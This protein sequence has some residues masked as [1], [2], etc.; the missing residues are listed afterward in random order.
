MTIRD[1]ST[2][3]RPHLRHEVPI[4]MWTTL[5][6]R[7]VAASLDVMLCPRILRSSRN[8]WKSPVFLSASLSFG[9]ISCICWCPSHLESIQ[10]KLA[11]E[12]GLF[13]LSA[14]CRIWKFEGIPSRHWSSPEISS[15][16]PWSTWFGGTPVMDGS[17]FPILMVPPLAG[18]DYHR[19]NRLKL[20]DSQQKKNCLKYQC[21]L[22][23]RAMRA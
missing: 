19:I 6:Q 2:G 7:A 4:S 20:Q 21:A 5:V 9:H 1:V 14:G 22:Q 16:K 18:L 3:P 23:I 11:M 17:P 13:F 10:I 15:T 8:G 12:L